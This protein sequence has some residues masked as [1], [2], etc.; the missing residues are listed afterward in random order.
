[1]VG[2]FLL[3]F[4]NPLYKIGNV[5]MIQRVIDCF[6]SIGL[7]N[8]IVASHPKIISDVNSMVNI[9]HVVNCQDPPLGTFHAVWS[10]YDYIHTKFTIIV[11]ADKPFIDPLDIVKMI[12]LNENCIFGYESFQHKPILDIDNNM[13]L[14]KI[15]E[16]VDDVSLYNEYPVR[17]GGV[18]CFKTD[19]LKKIDLSVINNNNFKKEYYLTDVIPHMS[20]TKV[21]LVDS[22]ISLSNINTMSEAT[23]L[24]NKLFN[25]FSYKS[26]EHKAYGRINLMGRHI[27]H[28]GGC[29]NSILVNKYVKVTLNNV[30]SLYSYVKLVSEYGTYIHNIKHTLLLTMP[31]WAKYLL[32]G[33]LKLNDDNLINLDMIGGLELNVT[34]NI[35][36]GSGISS[37]TAVVIAST[38][39]YLDMFNINMTNEELVIFT[40]NAEKYIGS[41]GGHGDHYAII[42][43]NFNKCIKYQTYPN[44]VLHE[45][46]TI[47]NSISFHIFHSGK[48]AFKGSS[49]KKKYN[50]KVNMYKKCFECIPNKSYL[51]EVTIDDLKYIDDNEAYNTMIY[52]IN[53]TH[54]ANKFISYL[55]E[56]NIDEIKKCVDSSQYD[57]KN[58]YKCSCDEVD[59]LVNIANSIHGVIGAQMIGAG[60]GGCVLVVSNKES[61]VIS[62]IEQ[63]GFKYIC[64]NT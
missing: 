7:K 51:T 12:E 43:G 61:N 22:V 14:N 35:P 58:L 8:I 41:Q 29:N 21:L 50:D 34:G 49:H 38:K 40:G 63:E 6:V 16:D 64:S 28:Q 30:K 5:S 4:Q 57:E 62:K 55:T 45:T 9:S 47:P 10:C 56:C 26:F 2:G 27:D 42:M 24:E 11:P 19:E 36:Q 23:L 18:Y 1:M 37:S 3:L 52:G 60:F 39:C 59:K 44:L 33:L 32:C 53:E 15:I 54:R 13:M 25:K 17:S 31:I 48:Y 46:V 20:N